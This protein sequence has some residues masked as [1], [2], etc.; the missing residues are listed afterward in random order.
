[1]V[2]MVDM[3]DMVDMIDMVDMVD[4]WLVSSQC[5]KCRAACSDGSAVWWKPT[6]RSEIWKTSFSSHYQTKIQTNLP[7]SDF[8]GDILLWFVNRT[9]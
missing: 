5:G 9:T 8:H 7:F 4:I 2:G 6:Q 1:M 3:V